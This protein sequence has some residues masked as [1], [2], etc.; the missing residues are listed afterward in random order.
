MRRRVPPLRGAEGRAPRASACR[1]PAVGTSAPPNGAGQCRRRVRSIGGAERHRQLEDTE[2]VI[3]IRL[4]C[5]RPGWFVLLSVNRRP[6]ERIRQGSA[7]VRI[8]RGGG[9][10]VPAPFSAK[11]AVAA[12]VMVGA[13]LTLVTVMATAFVALLLPSDAVTL[14]S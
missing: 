12:E 3:A 10:T 13:S 5:C 9:V 4:C 1:G 2:G 7:G 14:T 6:R 11:L 8:R